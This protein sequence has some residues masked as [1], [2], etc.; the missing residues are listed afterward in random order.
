MDPTGERT[1]GVLTKTDLIG[2]GNEEEV[3]AVVNNIRKPLTL[4]YVM[5]KNRSQ[6]EIAEKMST[7]RSRYVTRSSAAALVVA[8]MATEQPLLSPGRWRRPSS[9]TTRTFAAATRSCWA[10]ASCPRS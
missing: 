3:L 7:A 10:W 6:R 8:V 9:R 4:G 2:P 5:V 1:I